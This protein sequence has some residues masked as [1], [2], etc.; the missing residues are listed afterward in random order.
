MWPVGTQIK[1]IPG[2][3][4]FIAGTLTSNIIHSSD[5]NLPGPGNQAAGRFLILSY[6]YSFLI[7]RS[8]QVAGTYS[9]VWRVG[10]WWIDG[11]L[12]NLYICVCMYMYVC[13]HEYAHA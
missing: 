6:F 10:I 5:C 12:M 4:K 7:L 9:T 1:L 3:I 2:Q 13:V 8:E 11:G